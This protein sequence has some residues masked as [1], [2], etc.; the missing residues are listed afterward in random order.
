MHALLTISTNG[1]KLCLLFHVSVMQMYR[2]LLKFNRAKTPHI[3]FPNSASAFY[4]FGG[5]WGFGKK[6]A[7]PNILQADMRP[8]PLLSLKIHSLCVDKSRGRVREEKRPKILMGL[9]KFVLMIGEATIVG[10]YSVI[11]N[12]Y[13]SCKRKRNVRTK[14]T[15]SPS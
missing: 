4:F 6:S 1:Y 2:K 14:H 10:K 12:C 9:V 8:R 15:C 11:A 3:K 13:V 7:F 5:R